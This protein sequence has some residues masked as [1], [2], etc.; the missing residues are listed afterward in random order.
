MRVD[1]VGALVNDLDHGPDEDPLA[2]ARGC[3]L[4]VLLGLAILALLLSLWLGQ[5][6]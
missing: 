5:C 3:L 1:R 2:P 4:G 6:A